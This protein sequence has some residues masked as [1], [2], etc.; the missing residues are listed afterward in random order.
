MIYADNIQPEVLLVMRD[1]CESQK[2]MQTVFTI[3]ELMG[4]FGKN[5]SEKGYKDT[6]K[7]ALDILVKSDT[8]FW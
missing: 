8:S 5:D 6:Y 4:F 1:I 3:V 2:S 7:K